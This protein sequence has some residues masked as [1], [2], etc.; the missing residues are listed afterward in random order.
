[1]SDPTDGLTLVRLCRGGDGDAARRPFYRYAGR[2]ISL[3]RR[4]LS[5]S[6]ASR[7]DA[8]QVVQWVF[9]D[10]FRSLRRGR[11]LLEE[12]D[13]LGK[14]LVRMT[15]LRTLGEVEFQ[16]AAKCDPA[17]EAGQEHS[18]RDELYAVPSRGPGPEEAVAFLEQQERFLAKLGREERRVLE[19]RV[20]GHDSEDICKELETYSRKLLREAE[21]I[22]EVAEEEGL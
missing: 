11:F 21:H 4:R 8:E 10:F 17:R 22:R 9:C 19:M 20:D 5:R 1:M 14:P 18:D 13:D 2:L 12:E 15:V 3:A 7:V 16:K 6:F